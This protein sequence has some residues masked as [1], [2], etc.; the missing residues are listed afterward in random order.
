MSEKQV[1][2]DQRRGYSPV[3]W[4]VVR[5]MYETE[6]VSDV[7]L[8]ADVGIDRK[9]LRHR[10]DAEGWQRQPSGRTAEQLAAR[11]AH[12]LTRALAFKSGEWRSFD[13]LYDAAEAAGA[14]NVS[15]FL[16]YRRARESRSS[17]DGV[18]AGP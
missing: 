10:R 11:Y 18:A 15:A 2:T 4:E 1:S 6:A 3:F 17:Q 9:S 12:G 8:C 14:V 16:A 13:E 5:V 7:R